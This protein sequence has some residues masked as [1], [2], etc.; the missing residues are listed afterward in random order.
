MVSPQTRP[1]R[2]PRALNLWRAYSPGLTGS[3]GR[4]Q[5]LH[6]LAFSPRDAFPSYAQGDSNSHDRSHQHLMLARL[7]LRHARITGTTSRLK[8]THEYKQRR[9]PW[10]LT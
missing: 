3:C 9:S 10:R 2:K 4:D 8:L 5:C 7:P 6:A 1:F